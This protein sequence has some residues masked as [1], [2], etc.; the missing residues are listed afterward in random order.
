VEILGLDP[1]KEYRQL[2][3]RLG[4]ALQSVALDPLMT[5]RETLEMIRRLSGSREV[6]VREA[7]DEILLE[8]LGLTEVA[9]RIVA[10]YS[11][12]MA[13]RLDLACAL[14]RGPEVLLLDEPTTGLDVQSRHALW[15]VIREQREAGVTVLL[16]THDMR[17]AESL[18]DRVVVIEA[19][20]I[21]ADGTIPE[22]LRDHGRVVIEVDGDIDLGVVSGGIPGVLAEQTDVGYRFTLSGE[23]SKPESVL[24]VLARLHDGCTAAARLRIDNAS[25]EDVFLQLTGHD[26]G[27]ER[28]EDKVAF[29]ARARRSRGS[30]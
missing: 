29:A 10:A 24:M 13:R 26:A 25:V 28:V 20:R 16:T 6:R 11:G 23:S 21:V 8:R 5:G 30:R 4:V 14:V 3:R 9:D 1:L 18:A 2:R 22:L 7:A 19:G 17:E 15:D 27:S 12:G